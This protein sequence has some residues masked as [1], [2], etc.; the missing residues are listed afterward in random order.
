[1]NI[2]NFSRIPVALLNGTKNVLSRDVIGNRSDGHSTTTIAGRVHQMVEHAHSI[3]ELYPVL[4]APITLTKAAGAYAAFPTPI[5]IIPASTID[6]DFDIHWAIVSAISANGDFILRLYQGAGGSETVIATKSFVRNAV[7]SQEGALYVITPL[8]LAN[9]RISAA[10]SSG[11]A[12]Q[13]TA[14]LKLEF[15]KY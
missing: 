11:N 6:E 3:N 7:Q 10:I 9:A 8:I 2:G 15:H 12:G 13:D 5:E 1:M 4:S 14:D